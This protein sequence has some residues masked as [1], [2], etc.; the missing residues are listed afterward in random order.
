MTEKNIQKLSGKVIS[1]GQKT[2]I[3]LISRVKESR[4]YAK[5]FKVTKKIKVHFEKG[6]HR[7]GD[8]VSFVASRPYSKDKHFCLIG[9]KK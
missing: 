1:V 2:L 8:E 4:L 6:E 5:K 3:V 9:D 7:I